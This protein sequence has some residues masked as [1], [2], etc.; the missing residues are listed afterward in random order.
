MNLTGHGC[1]RRIKK[2][3]DQKKISTSSIRHTDHQ[4]FSFITS[5]LLL[6]LINE[7]QCSVII[8]DSSVNQINSPHAV[9]PVKVNTSSSDE[10]VDKF[11]SDSVTPVQ[12]DVLEEDSPSTTSSF[13]HDHPLDAIHYAAVVSEAVRS[14]IREAKELYEKIEPDLYHKGR[15][16]SAIAKLKK[17]GNFVV[18]VV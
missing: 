4:R 16:F 15:S 6:F 18:Q 5:V 8:E 13:P 3:N 14:G 2:I 7:L 10:G 9:L 17:Q 11:S 12:D 1:Q